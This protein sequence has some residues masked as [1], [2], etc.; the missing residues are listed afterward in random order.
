LITG[1]RISWS[2]VTSLLAGVWRVDAEHRA[3][4]PALLRPWLVANFFGFTA[5]GALGGGVLR[6]LG[7]PYYGSDVSA[8]E[9]ADIQA[10]STGLSGVIFGTFIGTAQWLVLRRV[11]RAGWWMPLTL[12]G[13]GLGT[14][15][16]G[17][18]SGGSV[19][20]IGP[21][22]SPVPPLLAFTVV[23][24]LVILLLG[25]GQWWLL[26]REFE[27]AGWWPVVNL[28]ALLFGFVVGI[29]VAKAVPFLA[30]THF[31]SAQAG[32]IAGLVAGPVYGL[33]TWAFLSELHRRPAPTD[34]PEE[35][36]SQPPVGVSR[37]A[38]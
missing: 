31:P 15:L 10:I 4:G 18:S 13:W 23:V 35:S 1:I 9:A 8:L 22:D 21:A 24:P 30:S 17:F 33:V 5:A 16:G 6:A 11:M 38:R 20:T 27:G 12:L 36:V 34:Q 14:A 25:G 26:R 29:G 32:G 2:I 37:R 19:S 3:V 28:V 7:E